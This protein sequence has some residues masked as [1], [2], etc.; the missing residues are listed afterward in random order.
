VQTTVL[1][2]ETASNPFAPSRPEFGATRFFQTLQQ[3]LALAT[4]TRQALSSERLHLEFGRLL[5]RLESQIPASA[6]EIS[7]ANNT[8]ERD[9]WGNVRGEQHHCAA[10]TLVARSEKGENHDT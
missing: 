5:G 8:N 1:L 9:K 6:I 4:S 3:H 10:Q 7:G 2:D